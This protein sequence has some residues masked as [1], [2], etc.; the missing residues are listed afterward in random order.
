M[1]KSGILLLSVLTLLA[2][3]ARQR[4]Q[5]AAVQ[6]QGDSLPT[7]EVAC[8]ESTG[9]EEA[10]VPAD[11][12]MAWVTDGVERPDSV[13]ADSIIPVRRWKFSLAD[14]TF[15]C[16]VRN[17]SVIVKAIEVDWQGHFYIVGGD[18]A[19]LVCYK[20][21]T[22]V[23][24]RELDAYKS[25]NALIRLDGDSLWIVEES[26]KTIIR[27]HKDGHGAIERYPIPFEDDDII[28]VGRLN[29]GMYELTAYKHIEITDEY[30][31]EFRKLPPEGDFVEDFYGT[32][33]YAWYLNFLHTITYYVFGY[34]AVPVEKELIGMNNY[35]DPVEEYTLRQGGGD[36]YSHVGY[37]GSY[38][39]ANVDIDT[40]HLTGSDRPYTEIALYDDSGES[41]IERKSIANR[42]MSRIPQRFIHYNETTTKVGFWAN[43]YRVRGCY[44]FVTGYTPGSGEVEIMAFDLRDML[45]ERSQDGLGT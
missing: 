39:G 28:D 33:E 31:E 32:K 38:H 2:C 4:G 10:E 44:L 45:P 27:L 42:I 7:Q 34:P 5:T 43:I 41:K 40:W 21:T 24:S 15:P 25:N 23:Y 1:K 11:S 36:E 13:P 18:P 37:A 9:A 17:D 8:T 3:S 19:R 29:D 14:G 26:L 6:E 16:T 20:G 30:M 22:P 12:S 35:Y